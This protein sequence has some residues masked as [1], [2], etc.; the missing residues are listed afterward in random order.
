MSLKQFFFQ[1]VRGLGIFFLI[2]TWYTI[3]RILESLCKAQPLRLFL[4]LSLVDFFP[5]P[6]SIFWYSLPK[7]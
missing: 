1:L 6:V 5:G 2:L 3:L 4:S 7:P